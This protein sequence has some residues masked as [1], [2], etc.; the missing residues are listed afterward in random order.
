MTFVLH[1]AICLCLVLIQTAFLPALSLQK[2]FYDLSIP[3]VIFLGLKRPF[4]ESILTILLLGITIDNL[5]GSP[6]FLYTTV[7]IWLVISVRLILKVAQVGT[8]LRLTALIIFGVLFEHMFL[9]GF[10]IMV[11]PYTKITYSQISNLLLQSFW[12]ALT[13]P[14]LVMM[15]EYFYKEMT[16]RMG[17]FIIAR[18]DQTSSHTLDS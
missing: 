14:L 16:E 7:Y 18:T 1:L 17:K 10:L 11:E 2:S 8:H 3:F 12:A 13:G 4:R 6:L 15:F 5:S 9:T